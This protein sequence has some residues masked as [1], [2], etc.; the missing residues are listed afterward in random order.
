MNNW[1]RPSRSVNKSRRWQV[2]RQQAKRRDGWQCVKCGERTRLEVDHIKPVRSNPELG[3]DLS[4]LQ[5][6]CVSCHSAKTLEEMGHGKVSPARMA[7]KSLLRN[8]QHKSSQ[9]HKEKF[10]VGISENKSPTVRD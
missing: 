4:N 3:F 7:W 9:Q 1:N 8:T 2:L 6:L 5:T 10:N